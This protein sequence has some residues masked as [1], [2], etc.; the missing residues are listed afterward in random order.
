[1]RLLLRAPCRRCRTS[2]PTTSPINILPDPRIRQ[3]LSARSGWPTIP[4]LFVDGD[5][6]RRLRHR[7]RARG[8]GRAREGR[9]S[10]RRVAAARRAD[11]SA[12][13]GRA[14]PGRPFAAL[15]HT[16]SDLAILRAM[17]A[18]LADRLRD[19]IAAAARRRTARARR[20]HRAL[21]L[22]AAT[23]EA[24]ARRAPGRRGRLLR[25]GAQR[26]RPR[27]DRRARARDRRARSG[28]STG[29]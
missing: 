18:L 27:A 9:R 7:G 15:E 23:R 4:Q 25:P 17:R 1:M 10:R 6:R 13:A 14:R 12:H 5:A 20:R 24:L 11:G 26:R 21:A 29:S 28:A 16:R 2:T 3:V 19:G 8:V 22:R